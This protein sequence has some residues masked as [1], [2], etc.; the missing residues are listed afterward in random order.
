MQELNITVSDH[1]SQ[2]DRSPHDVQT[3]LASRSEGQ[4]KRKRFTSNELLGHSE[5]SESK[6]EEKRVQ[7]SQTDL[8]SDV[9]SSDNDVSDSVV[10]NSQ[11]KTKKRR[12]KLLLNLLDE[13]ED[14]SS[15]SES[16]DDMHR[17]GIFSDITSP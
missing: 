5:N 15:S 12:H 6:F 16:D 3:S 2:N 8:S 17:L 13:G 14:S 4:L 11:H 1:H 9:D 10:N 7:R